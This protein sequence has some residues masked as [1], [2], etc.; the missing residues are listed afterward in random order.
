MSDPDD[1]FLSR[2]FDSDDEPLAVLPPRLN[3]KLYAIPRRA[4]RR[5]WLGAAAIAASVLVVFGGMFM[6]ERLQQLR[7][8]ERARQ[9]L[10]QALHYLQKANDI[11]ASR[12]EKRLNSSLQSATIKPMLDTVTSVSRHKGV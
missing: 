10:V 2:L 5:R 1:A 6:A 8:A 9:D 4:R 7:D 12:V 11:A 3:D